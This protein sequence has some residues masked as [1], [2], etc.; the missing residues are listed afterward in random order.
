MT[1]LQFEVAIIGGGAAGSAA[2][3][4]LQQHGVTSICIVEPSGFTTARVGETIPP[5]ANLLLSELGVDQAFA[6][7][8]HLPCYGS[9]SL[10]GSPQL[11]HNDYL[12]S[13]YGNG[14]H[15]DRVQFDKMLLEQ[16]VAGGAQRITEACDFVAVQGG[17]VSSVTAGRQEIRA[18]MFIDATGRRA[19]VRRAM[20]GSHRFH[21]RKLEN[22]QLEGRQFDDSQTVIWAM[23]C[24]PEAAF[25]HSTWLEAAPN[26]WWYAAE[27]PGGAAVVALGTDP[28][29]AKAGG[30]YKMHSWAAALSGTTLIAPRL[31]Q[32]RLRPDSFQITA[33][34]SY[35]A[36]RVVGENW[37]AVGDAACAF[38][39]LSSAGIYKALVNGQDAA[40]AICDGSSL[41]YAK[42]IHQDYETYLIKRAELYQAEQRWA[43]MPFWAQRQGRGQKTPSVSPEE[44]P[45]LT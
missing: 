15:L 2:A 25:G 14:W 1:G 40:R 33:S 23:F 44:M 29:L 43:E 27:V 34:H 28:K 20:G 11:G 17:R 13:P 24:L 22:C 45:A 19:V 42:R 32:A 7:Q 5:D 21:D 18:G 36:A 41:S 30:V 6:R 12:T 8:G 26:G 4:A 3:L 38:D 9:H 35:R 37:L 31:Q 10:W 39:P 16:A